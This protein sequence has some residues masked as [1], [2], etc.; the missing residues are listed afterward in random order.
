MREIPF[1][2]RVLVPLAEGVGGLALNFLPPAWA[3][4]IKRRLIAAGQPMSL[5]AFLTMVVM[6]GT[7]GP[8]AVLAAAWARSDGAPPAGVYVF[9]PAFAVLG[10]LLTLVWLLRRARKRQLAIWKS[11]PDAFDL[12]T[13]CVE[14]GLG[15]DGAF[16]LVSEKLS[17]PMGAEFAEMLREIGMGKARRDALSDMAER[18]GVPDLQTFAH[19]IVQ[20]EE[21]GTSLAAVLRVQAKQIRIRRTQRAEEEARRAP[22]KMIFPLVF[23]ILPSLFVVILGPLA[24]EVVEVLGE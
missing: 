5:A 18:T 3:S 15:L 6:A 21:L 23:F 9:M 19:S 10:V 2:Y 8:M 7:L 13:T 12:M 17:G 11:L 16:R 24:I 1:A 14:A 22:I 4:R 20:A